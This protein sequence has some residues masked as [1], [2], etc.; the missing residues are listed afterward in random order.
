MNEDEFKEFTKKRLYRGEK[1]EKT[2]VK[3]KDS[4]CI[5]DFKI[6]LH[7]DVPSER[8]DLIEERG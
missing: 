3:E 2:R 8:C 4:F 7:Q 6:V 1:E 5:H